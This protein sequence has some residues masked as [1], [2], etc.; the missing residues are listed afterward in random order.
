MRLVD[1]AIV[2]QVPVD[3]V[4]AMG[5]EKTIGVSLSFAM[6]PEKISGM[7]SVF[8][9]MLWMLGT[10]QLRRSLDSADLG[11]QLPGIDK[12]SI[13]DT[14][15]LDLIDIGEREMVQRLPLLETGEPGPVLRAINRIRSYRTSLR[16]TVGR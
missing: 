5:A 6:L 8:S 14:R 10:Q 9:S 7:A 2:D 4:K 1:G 11:F 15:Q 12:R 3:V 13:F 16:N